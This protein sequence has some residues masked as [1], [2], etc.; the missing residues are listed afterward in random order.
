MTSMWCWAALKSRV[1]Q[2]WIDRSKRIILLTVFAKT[3]GQRRRR[4]SG[5]SKRWSAVSQR[6]TKQ[7]RT[8]EP[9]DAVKGHQEARHGCFTAGV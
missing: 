7:R 9:A 4:W 8:N 6:S 1:T 3:R 5:P 2:G